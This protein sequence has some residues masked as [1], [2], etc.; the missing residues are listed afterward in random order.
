MCINPNIYLYIK[1]VTL[2]YTNWCTQEIYIKS[3]VSTCAFHACLKNHQRT[4]YSVIWLFYLF[5][6]LQCIWISALHILV[7]WTDWRLWSIHVWLELFIFSTV[8]N[9]A[10]YDESI[11][12]NAL[13]QSQSILLIS[14]S[15][16]TKHDTEQFS[17]M[18]GM[19]IYVVRS[20]GVK[21]EV[22]SIDCEIQT[23]KGMNFLCFLLFWES[24]NCS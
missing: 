14:S 16:L 3:W 8:P 7:I 20:S 2:N 13:C 17:W 5:L 6:Y 15:P 12:F 4:F 11:T 22:G 9:Q 19:H 1:N 24:F 10:A 23:E 21:L 18:K